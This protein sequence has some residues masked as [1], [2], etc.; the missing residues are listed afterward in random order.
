[1]QVKETDFARRLRA[2]P[3]EQ[4]VEPLLEKLISSLSEQ[5]NKSAS[6]I[7]PDVPFQQIAP[8]LAS[9]TLRHN[10]FVQPWTVEHLGFRSYHSYETTLSATLRELATYLAWSLDPLPLPEKTL[11]DIEITWQWNWPEPQSYEGSRVRGRTLFVL[12]SGRS[13]TS[14]FRN[15]LDCHEEVFA[16]Q[17]LH[18]V[19]FESMAERRDAQKKLAQEWMNT[20]LRD[21]LSRLF[22]HSEHTAVLELE[23]FAKSG[24]TSSDVYQLIHDKLENRWLVDKTPVYAKHPGWLQRAEQMFT[25]PCYVHLTRHP[26]AV[27]ESFISKRFYMYSPSIWGERVENPWHAAE[28]FWTM[29]NEN[30][31]RFSENIPN[32]RFLWITYEELMKDSKSVIERVCSFLQIPFR[33]N[34]LDPYSGRSITDI[35]LEEHSAIDT[36]MGEAWKERRPPHTLSERTRRVAAELGYDLI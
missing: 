25:E 22:G 3:R 15:M 4:R 21:T 18:L 31:L 5:L 23:R 34:M 20:G 28:L 33:E 17:E 9:D 27:M 36:S 24:L 8:L 11:D 6:E 32:S 29:A 14:L 7:D 26:Y 13:G 1:M 10:L 2:K 12:S 30:I 35:N 16:P 19:N